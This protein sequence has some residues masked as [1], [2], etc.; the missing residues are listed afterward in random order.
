M[1]P[2]HLCRVQRQRGAEHGQRAAEQQRETAA[3]RAP[4]IGQ[5][6]DAQSRDH[7]RADDADIEIRGHQAE[8][9]HPRHQAVA[10]D[11]LE[12][13]RLR[14]EAQIAQRQRGQHH[15][16][17]AR[18]ARR[19]HSRH[20]Q[21]RD[22]HA[23]EQGEIRRQLLGHPVRE[24]EAAKERLRLEAHVIDARGPMGFA[25][26]LEHRQQLR[27]AQPER[28][29]HGHQCRPEQGTDP[30]H[31]F[32]AP[33][34][35][36]RDGQQRQEQEHHDPLHHVRIARQHEIAH[37]QRQPQAAGHVGTPQQALEGEHHPGHGHRD[38]GDRQ[39]ALQRQP[40]RGADRRRG[41]EQ[42]ARRAAAELAA[43][44]VHAEAAE[45][46][47]QRVVDVDA[48]ERL[49][50]RGDQQVQRIQEAALAFGKDRVPDIHEI[51][52]Q[53]AVVAVQHLAQV[54]QHRDAVEERV[55]DEDRARAE[56]RRREQ[57]RREQRQRGRQD[58]RRGRQVGTAL[59][60][61]HARRGHGLRLPDWRSTERCS[62]L[63]GTLPM[64]T[65]R[66]RISRLR[67]TISCSATSITVPA[68]AGWPVA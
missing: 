58:Q 48:G 45:A 46:G 44:Q 4:G 61:G 3:R 34:P 7:A 56:Q 12:A 57:R 59:R 55:T 10:V 20:E 67:L 53:Q 28:Q 14:A 51:R 37:R 11:E 17:C 64:S 13:R 26:Q 31:E 1:P 47:A 43:Q 19:E 30:R 2:V 38:V 68:V 40:H 52:P 33:R 23:A 15:A 32:A 18:A 36:E 65:V 62:T 21:R 5:R 16:D 29:H 54:V 66:K 63:R 39:V 27:R 49:E 6:F 9:T 25:G 22:G 50:Q 41:A 35:A 8:E 60:R 24:Q 42:R